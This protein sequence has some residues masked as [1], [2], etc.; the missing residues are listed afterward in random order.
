MKLSI[1]GVSRC[2]KDFFINKLID[3]FSER[4]VPL[5]HIKGSESLN[6]LALKKFNAPFKSLNQ[7]QQ[8]SLRKDFVSFVKSQ[9]KQYKNIVVDGH[10]SFYDENENLC[11]VFTKHDLNCYDRFFYLDTDASKVVEYSKNST[12]EKKN[13]SITESK[14]DAWKNHEIECLEGLLVSQSKELHIIKYENEFALQYVFDVVSLD[15]YNSYKAALELLDDLPIKNASTI[16]VTDCDKT[17]SLEDTTSIMLSYNKIPSKRTKEIF[18]NDRYSPFQFAL[19]NEFYKSV[20]VF[21]DQAIQFAIENV[22]L[23]NK[24]IDDLKSKQDCLILGVTGG[25]IDT[26]QGIFE[27][28][29]LNATVLPIKDVISKYL[30]FFIVRI[31]K[32]RGKFVISIGDSMLDSLMIKEASIGYIAS[33]KGYRKNIDDFLIKNSHIR[34]LSCFDFQYEYL[35]LDSSISTLKVLN[36]NEKAKRHIEL[37][38]SSS[39]VEGKSLRAAHGALGKEVANLIRNDFPNE[40]FALVIMLR[41]GIL[42]GLGIGDYLDCPILFYDGSNKEKLLQEISENKNLFSRKFILCDAVINSGK[43]IDNAIRDLSLNSPIIAAAVISDKYTQKTTVPIYSS[44]ISKNSYV[45]AKQ[46]NVSRGKGPDT[47]DRLFKLI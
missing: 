25:N 47:S 3:F 29:R 11:T 39:G 2:G 30:K 32:E 8:S 26:W 28:C 15:K 18:L 23:H 19:A 17:L 7:S 43:S 36:P 24:M 13:D 46:K 27:K 16:I 44:R 10:F 45:G 37:C 12:G 14:V 42:F 4:G 31:L 9:E 21:T 34:C 33:G 40:K 38:K 35:S 20:N 22:H 41:S 5:K 6:D 1:Y